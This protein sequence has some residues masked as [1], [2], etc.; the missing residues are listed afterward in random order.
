MD[1]LF[2]QSPGT[3]RSVVFNGTLAT[4]A[5]Y[6]KAILLA[7]SRL[8][9]AG[10]LIIFP[11]HV[12]RTEFLANGDGDR[13]SG[14]NKKENRNEIDAGV[15]ANNGNNGNEND[16][17][18]NKDKVKS[19]AN[20]DASLDFEFP[21]TPP[22]KRPYPNYRRILSI[23]DLLESFPFFEY[24]HSFDTETTPWGSEIIGYRNAKPVS[25]ELMAS[26]KDG[27]STRYSRLLP[28]LQERLGEAT[29]T[30]YAKQ[31]CDKARRLHH[32]TRQYGA[33]FERFCHRADFRYLEIGVMQGAS[34]RAAREYFPN[35]ER[36]VGID[37]NIDDK[38]DTDNG[39]IYVRGNATD[40]AVIARVNAEHGPFDLIIDDGSH[41]FRDIHL[42]F[43]LAFPLLKNGGTYIVEDTNV[44]STGESIYVQSVAAEPRPPHLKDHLT[45]FA[46]RARVLSN[47]GIPL[48]DWLRGGA[49]YSNPEHIHHKTTDPF[50]LGMDSVF[51]GVGFVA[52]EKRVRTN[53]QI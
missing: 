11:Q 1:A 23:P 28:D 8:E 4:C 45:Y 25:E 9:P 2:K 33:I 6:A 37:I 52:I 44:V 18:E 5:E 20:P 53:W 40:P 10:T 15:A 48:S 26:L 29:D 32:Y 3:L 49:Y 42:T 41:V 14:E 19:A 7:T 24:Y 36:I 30:V 27:P 22:E 12:E 31:G 46:N 21:D 16:G 17:G 13:E 50:T 39:M 34:M 38:I 43:E 47:D 51:F 35:A